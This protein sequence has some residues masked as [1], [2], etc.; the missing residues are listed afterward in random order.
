M[1]VRPPT[2]RDKRRY[3]L[4]R[5][6][7]PGTTIDQKELYYAVSD[8]VSSLWGD[9]VAG[10]I[11]QAVIC[12][13]GDYVVIRCRRGTERELA[14]ALST[15]TRLRDAKI[16]LR[17]ISASGTIES[18][19]DRM[20]PRPPPPSPDVVPEYRFFGKDYVAVHCDGQKVDVIEKGFKNTSR[21]FLTT[22]DMETE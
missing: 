22:E 4:V 12:A 7:P 13:E 1:A 8:A 9:A 18:L 16:A 6:D 17:I 5:V 21:L 3:L 10:I 20:K 14:I 11:V 2:L 15:V 19:R